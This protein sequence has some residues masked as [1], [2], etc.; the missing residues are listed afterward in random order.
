MFALVTW[1]TTGSGLIL[2]IS[3]DVGDLEMDK[4]WIDS[5]PKCL[6]R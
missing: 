5:L 1:K 4:M 6:C 2:V 3:V